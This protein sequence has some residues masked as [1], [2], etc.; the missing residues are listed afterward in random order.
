[1]DDL[2][3]YLEEAKELMDKAVAHT[4]HE[5]VKIRAGKASP[6]MLDG[7]A[8]EYYGTMTPLNQAAT[9]S[10]P[11][12]RMLTIR[13][14]EKSL[15]AEIERAIINSDLGFNP[16][17]D[18]EQVIINI[19]ILTEERR[20]EL[21]KQVKHEGEL[22]KISLRTVRKE[23]ND[24]LRKLQKEGV[25]EDAVRDAEIDVQEQTDKH[26]KMIE[27]LLHKKEEEI[28]TV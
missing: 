16:Q 4:A 26:T 20:I 24:H 17:S 3:F 19:P 13:P 14:F 8:I 9:I 2:E 28:M 21:T 10:T 5:L 11:D 1:M 22:G 7:L 27:D 6:S 23:I 12:A 25:S 15:I 18:G